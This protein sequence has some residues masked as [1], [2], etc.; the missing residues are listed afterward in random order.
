MPRFVIDP[1]AAGWNC[2]APVIPAG[3]RAAAAGIPLARMSR[4]LSDLSDVNRYGAPGLGLIEQRV[5]LHERR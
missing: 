5:E 4:Q 2:G 1:E 3:Q